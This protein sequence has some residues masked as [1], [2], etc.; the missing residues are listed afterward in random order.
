M[1]ALFDVDHGTFDVIVVIAVIGLLISAFW[2][3]R[4]AD[5]NGLSVTAGTLQTLC[6]AVFAFAFLFLT[7]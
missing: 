3:A 1:L 2:S 4:R 7:P 6:L 5:G